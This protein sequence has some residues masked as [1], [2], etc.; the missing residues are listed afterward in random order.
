M[1]TSVEQIDR[2]YGHLLPDSLERA[3]GALDA[4]LAA[5]R[6]NADDAPMGM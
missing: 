3:R 4:F 1:G 2:T 6:L 5:E